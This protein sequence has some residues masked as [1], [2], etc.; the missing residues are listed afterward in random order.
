MAWDWF[1]FWTIVLIGLL[2]LALV[3]TFFWFISLSKKKKR[4]PSHIQLYFD[5]N[6]RSILGEWDFVTRDR[7]K[8]FK[9]DITKR[10]V[11]VGGDIDLLEKKRLKLDKR[12]DNLEMKIKDLEGL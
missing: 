7:I 3:V 11:S 12:M 2:L 5:E 6:F 1:T 10:L 9:K 4:E 8:D